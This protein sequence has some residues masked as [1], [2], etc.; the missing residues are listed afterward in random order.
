MPL[1]ERLVLGGGGDQVPA[2]RLMLYGSPEDCQVAGF[3][4][5]AGENQILPGA[6]KHSGEA[7]TAGL[8]HPLCGPAKGVIAAG[9]IPK[10]LCEVGQHR[11]HNLRIGRSGGV[12]VEVDRKLHGT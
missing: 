11:R 12:V 10:M 8:H 2:A 1:V 5:A 7:I 6:V 9:G 4:R 3:R